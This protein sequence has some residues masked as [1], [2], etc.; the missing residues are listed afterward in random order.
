MLN[1]RSHPGAP[2]QIL[3]TLTFPYLKE[4]QTQVEFLVPAVTSLCKL[5]ERKGPNEHHGE[6]GTQKSQVSLVTAVCSAAVRHDSREPHSKAG[7]SILLSILMPLPVV[8]LAGTKP[9]KEFGY[10]FNT[11]LNEANKNCSNGYF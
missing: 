2:R 9:D 3:S 11:T 10:C 5:T 1:P 6:D 8:R 4:N 7:V